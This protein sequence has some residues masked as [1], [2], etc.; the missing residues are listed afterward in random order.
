MA[1]I[2]TEL[3]GRQDAAGLA[4][5]GM[6]L[7][8]AEFG[9]TAQALGSIADAGLNGLVMGS[10]ITGIPVGILAHVVHRKI[11]QRKLKE[12]ELDEQLEYYRNAANGLEAGL[13]G[14]GVTH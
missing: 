4:K 10:L 3:L 9:K 14:Y 5:F 8:S 1:A 13:A 12:Q 2:T 7:E 11:K 6:A